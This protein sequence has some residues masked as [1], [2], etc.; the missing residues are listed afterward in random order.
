MKYIKFL[1]VGILFGIVLSKSEAISWYRILEMFRFESFHMYG[2]IGVAV[3]VGAIIVQFIK[4]SKLKDLYGEEITFQD[5]ARSFHRYFWGGSIFG[6][7]WAMTGACPGPLYIL[8]GQGYL[9]LL[10]TILSAAVGTFLYGVLQNKL[11][12]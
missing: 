5:K 3:I 4:R 6:L 7:G 2:I 12:H 11:P 1:S 8:V 9:I 10:V